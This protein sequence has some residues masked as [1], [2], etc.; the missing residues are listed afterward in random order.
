LGREKQPKQLSLYKR[1]LPNTEKGPRTF[2]VAWTSAEKTDHTSKGR[3]PGERGTKGLSRI[4]RLTLL[5]WGGER[6]TGGRDK[7]G[8]IAKNVGLGGNTRKTIWQQGG[9]TGDDAVAPLPAESPRREAER[10]REN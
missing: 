6:K 5:S 8:L 4:D 1:E 2:L 9:K 3:K 10:H 7:T